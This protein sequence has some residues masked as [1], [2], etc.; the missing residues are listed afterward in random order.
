[1][2]GT[3]FESIHQTGRVLLVYVKCLPWESTLFTHTESI[4]VLPYIV[5]RTLYINLSKAYKF[6]PSIRRLHAVL[7]ET[8]TQLADTQD[9]PQ[10]KHLATS[11]V[12]YKLKCQH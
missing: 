3:D 4:H 9:H 10:H 1:M 6:F 2:S 12:T 8:Q 11:R 5:I 7:T